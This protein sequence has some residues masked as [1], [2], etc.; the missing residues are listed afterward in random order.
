MENRRRIFELFEA[1]KDVWE[2][3][4]NDG[5]ETYRKG[6]ANIV[7]KDENG[8]ILKDARIKASQ[9]THEFKFGANIFMLD[10]LENDEKNNLYKKYFK[11][12]FNM[13]TLPFYW[14]DLEPEQGKTRY[15]KDSPKIYRRPSI[16]LCMEFCEE[17][18]IEPREHALAYEQFFPKWIEGKPTPEVKELLEKRYKEI[19]ERYADKIPTIEVVNEMEW[20]KGK[21]D[22]YDDPDYI[23]W[24]FKMAEKYFPNNELVIN[25][26]NKLSFDDPGCRVTT[27]YFAY[28]E[29]AMLKGARI[30]AIGMQY[31]MCYP[32]EDEYDVTRYAYYNPEEMY[33]RLDLYATLGKPLQITEIT[34]PAYDEN[35]E[36]EEIQAELLEKLYTLW[37]SHPNME[38]IIYWN[39]I[40]GYAFVADPDPEKIR[41]SQGDMTLGENL[42]RGGL[43]R[44]DLSPKPAFYKLQELTQKV[45]HTEAEVITDNGKATF[46]G[47]YGK[48]DVEI[49]VNGKTVKREINLSKNSDNYFE[50][51]L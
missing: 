24:C 5:I 27:K 25:E 44:F 6:D 37:F 3:R 32:Q 35:P 9:K 46:R 21:T 4:A 23:T 12:T 18:G 38:Q 26:G 43:L 34:F 39:L 28:I 41:A 48:Y 50:I 15:E 33:R 13:A 7:L 49:T 47:F 36:N 10:E 17:N 16:D 1:Q 11:E 14:A 31:H 42:F 2:R 22:F 45:W 51:I 20:K 40:D 8:N 19:A 29:N 30:D